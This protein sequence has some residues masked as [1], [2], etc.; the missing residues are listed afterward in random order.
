M[1]QIVAAS[2]AFLIGSTQLIGALANSPGHFDAT[3]VAQVGR[4]PERLCHANSVPLVFGVVS[5]VPSMLPVLQG[6]AIDAAGILGFGFL[7]KRD[8]AARDRQLA[9]LSRSGTAGQSVCWQH[10]FM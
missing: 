1:V 6:L 7:V 2:L 3:E 9:R 5:Q 10:L 4:L 8:L